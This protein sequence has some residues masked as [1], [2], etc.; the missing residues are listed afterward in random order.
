MQSE[1]HVRRDLAVVETEVNI[2][3]LIVEVVAGWM[4]W[5]LTDKTRG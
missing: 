3:A 1:P 2:D 5:K 4:G